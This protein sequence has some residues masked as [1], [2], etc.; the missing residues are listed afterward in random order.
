MRNAGG[1]P[2]TSL[3]IG[4][5]KYKTSSPGGETSSSKMKVPS[6]LLGDALFRFVNCSSRDLS[7][8]MMSFLSLMASPLVDK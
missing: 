6:R 4:L 5:G 2:E 3:S 1:F 7:G 8:W